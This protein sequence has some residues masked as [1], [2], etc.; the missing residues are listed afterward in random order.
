M[1]RPEWYIFWK[2]VISFMNYS[3]LLFYKQCGFLT[4]RFRYQISQ[5]KQN[6]DFHYLLFSYSN[7]IGRACIWEGWKYSHA[8]VH[9]NILPWT[10]L[11]SFQTPAV[12]K[13]FLLA[14]NHTL[15]VVCCTP[16][17]KIKLTYI[18]W[19]FLLHKWKYESPKPNSKPP[20]NRKR[21]KRG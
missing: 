20:K 3:S 5:A 6:S 1:Q 21:I 2:L 11:P 16:E 14:Q 12:S 7:E 17:I 4:L 8:P 18:R 19:T 9:Q 10:G 13:R 15:L